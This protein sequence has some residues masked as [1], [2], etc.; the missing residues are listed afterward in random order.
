M[1]GSAFKV[2]TPS[3]NKLEEAAPKLLH[4]CAIGPS[5][6]QGLAYDTVEPFGGAGPR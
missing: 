3:I 1:K 5:E 4:T 2:A 6:A